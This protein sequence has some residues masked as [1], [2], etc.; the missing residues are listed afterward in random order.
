MDLPKEWIFYFRLFQASQVSAP[1]LAKWGRSFAGWQLPP[2][3][4]Y[5]S[6]RSFSYRRLN[7]I[8]DL[9]LNKTQLNSTSCEFTT[10]NSDL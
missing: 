7:V 4:V 10:G 3:M 1:L 8:C 9:V 6:A 5:T 2:K